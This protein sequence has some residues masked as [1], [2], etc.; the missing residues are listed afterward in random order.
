VETKDG[1]RAREFLQAAYSQQAIA[2]TVDLIFDTYKGVKLISQRFSQ[3]APQRNLTAS[4]VVGNFVLFANDARVLKTAINQ[5]QVP[6]LSL[7]FSDSYREVAQAI[8]EPRLGLAYVNFP[9]LSAWISNLPLPE[10]PELTQT[11]TVALSLKNGGIVARTALLGISGGAA[12]PALDEPVGALNYIPPD[13]LLAISGKDLRNLW[14]HITEELPAESPIQQLL[15]RSTGN[16]SRT[17]GLDLPEA[18]FS[19]ATGEY[20]LAL[21]P[22]SDR[23]GLDWL[24]VAEKT[25]SDW[26]GAIA[27]LDRLAQEQGF[28]VGQLPLLDGTVTAWTKLQTS[29][30][31]ADRRLAKL[32]AQV[33]GVRGESDR[34]VVLATSLAALSQSLTAATGSL[35]PNATLQRAIAALPAANDGY[36]YLDWQGISPS[37][38]RQFPLLRV[39][40][41]PIQ[42]FFDNLRSLVVTSQGSDRHIRRSTLFLNFGVSP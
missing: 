34:Y 14:H 20:S 16:L 28:S 36:L 9:A 39:V 32:E 13:C 8:A 29:V 27:N 3:P 12:Q 18:I 37:L 33:S 22:S 35:P 24:F 10:L 17:L 21:L 11:L 25:E 40:E 2:G 23:Q 31:S 1:D 15:V 6:D 41:L 26:Q 7:K 19:W 30:P 5:L 4:A 42:P 38:T